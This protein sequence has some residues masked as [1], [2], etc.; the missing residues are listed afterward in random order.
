M[1]DATLFYGSYNRGIKGGN[2][3]PSANV[4]LDNI[5][6]DEEV[7]HA[8]EIGVKTEFY[9]G[10]ARFNA[11]VMARKAPFPSAAGEVM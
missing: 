7:L 1:D 4:G 5:R 9:D 8:F 2:F 10:L 6:H 3:A 11:A